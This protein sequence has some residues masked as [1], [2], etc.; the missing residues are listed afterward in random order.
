M[1]EQGSNSFCIEQQ[2][3]GVFSRFS[4]FETTENKH[5]NETELFKNNQDIYVNQ[6]NDMVRRGA[7][8]MDNYEGET[9]V[10]TV[11]EFGWPIWIIVA[12]L[13][14]FGALFVWAMIKCIFCPERKIVKATV[15]LKF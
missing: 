15:Y 2:V 14:G 11:H 6:F 9:P 10:F 13:G 1:V 3:Q 7:N 4:G 12:I 8:G 5:F